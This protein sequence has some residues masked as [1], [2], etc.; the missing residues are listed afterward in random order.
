MAYG[1]EGSMRILPSQSS[2]MNRKVGSTASFTTLQIEVVALGDA[3]P[4]VHAGAAQG[5]DA[6]ANARSAD[7]RPCR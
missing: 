2:D 7:E 4:I 6:H 5:I 3:R 1:D